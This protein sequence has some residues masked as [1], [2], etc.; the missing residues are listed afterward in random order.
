MQDLEGGS[1][2]QQIV[3]IL[4]R[5]VQ[6]TGSILWPHLRSAALCC[7]YVE[8]KKSWHLCPS[9]VA[10]SWA[11]Y[12]VNVVLSYNFAKHSRQSEESLLVLH[13]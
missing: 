9:Q 4:R 7:H 11:E 3:F 8:V 10:G 1:E 2:Q 6:D 12:T 13:T 5:W